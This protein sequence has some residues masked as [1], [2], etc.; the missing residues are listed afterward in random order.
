MHSRYFGACTGCRNEK[1]KRTTERMHNPGKCFCASFD[2][3]SFFALFRCG[4]DGARE[5]KKSTLDPSLLL[6]SL[7]S[8][9]DFLLILHLAFVPLKLRFKVHHWIQRYGPGS[10]QKNRADMRKKHL[11]LTRVPQNVIIPN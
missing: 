7:H 3:F 10:R 9:L 5:I 4:S 1:A 8:L 11:L 2:F 6:L